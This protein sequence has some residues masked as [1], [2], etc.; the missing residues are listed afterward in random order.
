MSQITGM[1]FEVWD[2]INLGSMFSIDI[3]NRYK[4]GRVWTNE[5]AVDENQTYVM[6]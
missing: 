2:L 5:R 1:K 3:F 4:S 6:G